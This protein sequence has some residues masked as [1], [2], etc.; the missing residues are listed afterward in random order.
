M[1]EKL[2]CAILDQK[3]IGQSVIYTLDAEKAY[4]I[5]NPNSRKLICEPEIIGYRIPVLL[6]QPIADALRYFQE[7]NYIIR[8]GLNFPI[9]AACSQIGLNISGVSFLTSERIF[10]ENR[11]SRI[12]S[13]YRKI[14]TINNAT[15]V[16]GDIIASGE[17]LNNAIQYIEEQYI[18][19]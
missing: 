12:E 1:R 8:G 16:I 7:Q 15:V 18:L 4:I 11:V 14:N 13:K 10:L 3:E 17:T 19:A 2:T 6:Q 9:E 5:S